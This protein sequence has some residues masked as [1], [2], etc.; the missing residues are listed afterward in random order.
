MKTKT[1]LE[2]DIIDITMKIHSEFPEL[3][4]YISE[5]PKNDSGID[6]AAMGVKNFKEYYNSLDE[7][8]TEYTK[9]H[10]TKDNKNAEDSQKFPGYP[11]YPP[12]EDIYSKGK[13]EKNLNPEDVSKQKS[14]N[15]QVGSRN[16]RDFEDDRSG[17]DLDVP[18]S[19]LDN[20]QES[21][22]SEDEENNYYSLGGDAH[23]DLDEDK[24]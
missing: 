7:L 17:S 2:R 10:Q 21:V 14:P 15:E 3:S 16:E 8:L 19:E 11:S 12:S 4:K 13:E 20:Q 23:N 9:T 5:M 1:E 24:G 22:G 18:G 6:P